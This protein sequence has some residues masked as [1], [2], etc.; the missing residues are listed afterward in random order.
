MHWRG[1]GREWGEGAGAVA[2][3][4]LPAGWLK[5]GDSLPAVGRGRRVRFAGA[6]A[7]ARFSIPNNVFCCSRLNEIRVH[8]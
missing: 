6:V 2:C 1:E 5:A 8:C 4:S 3:G 7:A